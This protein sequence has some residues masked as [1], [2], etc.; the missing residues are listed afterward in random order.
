MDIKKKKITSI[1]IRQILEV[2]K[3]HEHQQRVPQLNDYVCHAYWNVP[4]VFNYICA[5][6]SCHV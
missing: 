5:L 4:Y 1:G 3:K 6:R 2:K